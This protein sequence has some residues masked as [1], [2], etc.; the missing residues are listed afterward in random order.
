MTDIVDALLS[1][2]SGQG[3][4]NFRLQELFG[5]QPEVLDAVRTLRARGVSYRSIGK[6]I[7]EVT[8]HYVSPNSVQNW[9]EYDERHR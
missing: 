2:E 3:G 4:R 1:A 5:D 7:A 9:L 8:G 6:K